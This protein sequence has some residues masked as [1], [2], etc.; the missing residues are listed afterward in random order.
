MGKDGGEGAKR[1]GAED[2]VRKKTDKGMARVTGKKSYERTDR[3]NGS[4]Q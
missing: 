4:E 1:K 3:K 2:T